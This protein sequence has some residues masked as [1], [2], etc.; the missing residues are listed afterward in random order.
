M[1]LSN[2]TDV[3]QHLKKK[4]LFISLALSDHKRKVMEKENQVR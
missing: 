1:P 3:I 2:E 4:N